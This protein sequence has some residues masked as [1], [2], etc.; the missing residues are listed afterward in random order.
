VSLPGI[1]L[2]SDSTA[3][4]LRMLDELIREGDASEQTLNRRALALRWLRRSAEA[5]EAYRTLLNHYPLRKK[6]WPVSPMLL[7][8]THDT[9]RRWPA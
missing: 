2:F 6:A 7:P 8:T 5:Q 4:A 1:Y 3:E 9:R